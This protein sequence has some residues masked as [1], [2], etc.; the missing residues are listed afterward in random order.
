MIW[1]PILLLLA[2]AGLLGWLYRTPAARALAYHPQPARDHQEA[3]DRFQALS[4]EHP[5]FK[6]TEVRTYIRKS[7]D[8]L[9]NPEKNEGFFSHLFDVKW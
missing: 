7:Q 4:Q 3:L 5:N 6:P 1:W 2:L 8:N 9:A